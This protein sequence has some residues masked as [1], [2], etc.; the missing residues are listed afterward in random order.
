MELYPGQS[1]WKM[2]KKSSG[3][4]ARRNQAQYA[5]DGDDIDACMFLNKKIR[6]AY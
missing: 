2:A 4:P 1:S 6:I 5:D 3:R